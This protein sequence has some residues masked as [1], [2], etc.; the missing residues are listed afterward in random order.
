MCLDGLRQSQGNLAHVYFFCLSVSSQTVAQPCDSLNVS[1]SVSLSAHLGLVR[2][3]AREKQKMWRGRGERESSSVSSDSRREN[4]GSCAKM[5]EGRD[6]PDGINRTLFSANAN[7]CL[8]FLPRGLTATDR[9]LMTFR[10][11][12]L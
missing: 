10:H 8:I 7:G 1:V 9:L 12:F 5:A 4:P 6:F 11:D 2:E 3:W